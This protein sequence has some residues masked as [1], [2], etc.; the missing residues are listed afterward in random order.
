MRTPAHCFPQRVQADGRAVGSLRGGIEHGPEDGEIRA[1]A[2]GAADLFGGVGGNPDKETRRHDGPQGCRL[3]RVRGQVY[4]VG[5][6]GERH[7]GPA[8]HQDAG[9]VR[10]G[11]CQNA[12]HQCHQ[13]AGGEVFFPDLNALD[14]PGERAR[15]GIDE[16]FNPAQGMAVRNVV[17]Q[18]YRGS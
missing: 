1:F 6:R 12:P 14:A 18:H 16:R 5:A 4:P 8:V 15:D 7:V 2:F 17:A 3:E 10:V 11:Q 13:L 9:A